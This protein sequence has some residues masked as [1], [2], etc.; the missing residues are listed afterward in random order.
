MQGADK[1]TA[2]EAEK[3][4]HIRMMEETAKKEKEQFRV[5]SSLILSSSPKRMAN[6]RSLHFS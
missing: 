5:S 6:M 4:L 1:L 2:S 3:I